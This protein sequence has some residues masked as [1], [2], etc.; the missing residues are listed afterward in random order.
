[1]AVVVA[2]DEEP[3]A[4]EEDEEKAD[5][6]SARHVVPPSGFCTSGGTP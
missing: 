5:M 2:D 4:V 3:T 1:M 6:V